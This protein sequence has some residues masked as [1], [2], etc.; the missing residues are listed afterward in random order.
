MLKNA[1]MIGYYAWNWGAGS[2]GSPDATIGV[3]F[4]GLNDVH[5]AV[6]QY[7]P[8]C[9]WCCP[10]LK[11]P[12]GKGIIS[13]G[14]GNTAGIFTEDIL[15]SITNDMDYIVDSN[16]YSGIILDVEICQGPSDGL[17]K[18]FNKVIDAAK[19]AGLTVGITSSH[20][21]PYMT[22]T[23]QVAVDLVKSWAAHDQLDYLSPQLYSSGMEGAPCLLETYACQST[24][25]TWDLY[26]GFKGKFIP[27][28][29]R[30][31]HYEES[32]KFFSEKYGIETAGYIMWAQNGRATVQASQNELFIN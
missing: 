23:P 11:G 17:I 28:I 21:A 6:D 16:Q 5:K 12:E 26:K 22:D 14:G 13:I 25:C 24:G 1:T 8:G 30:P 31:S 27:S 7:T 19:K 15:D 32:Q 29:V 4:T 2:H 18:G 9:A 3:A 10:V 20:S